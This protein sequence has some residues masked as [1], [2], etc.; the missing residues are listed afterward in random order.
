MRSHLQGLLVLVGVLGSTAN[1][2]AV[3]KGSVQDSS[4]RPLVGVQV[5][6]EG[7]G[8]ETRTDSS[9]RYLLSV[10]PETYSVRFRQLGYGPLTRRAQLIRGASTVVDAVLAPG[11]VPQLDTVEVRAIRPRGLGREGFDER[12]ALGLGKFLDSAQLRT[13]EGRKLHDVLRDQGVRIW[14]TKGRYNANFASNP[15]KLTM[16]GQPECYMSVILDGVAIYRARSRTEV[17]PDFSRDFMI[18][19]LESVEVYR[20]AAQTPLEFSG[21]DLDCGVIVMW[22][23]RRK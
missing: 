2:Q 3:I 5:T 7:T 13:M 1:A 6:L 14:Q 8:R 21:Y 15:I 18:M 22:T 17:P 16:S 20:G 23:R 12:R 9:G 10:A 19:S 11:D 4:G